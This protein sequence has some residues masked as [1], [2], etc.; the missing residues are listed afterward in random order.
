[1]FL[2]VGGRLI[3]VLSVKFLNFWFF[4]FFFV[5]RPVGRGRCVVWLVILGLLRYTFWEV[6]YMVPML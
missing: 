2:F 3:V 5:P 1:M 4:C 6:V